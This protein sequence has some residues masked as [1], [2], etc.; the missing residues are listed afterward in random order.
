MDNG[1]RHRQ[2]AARQAE[3]SIWPECSCCR[4]IEHYQLLIEAEALETLSLKELCHAERLVFEALAC[5][6]KHCPENHIRAYCARQ[7]A[8][9]WWE[10][11]RNNDFAAILDRAVKRMGT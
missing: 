1:R 5:A 9:R 4:I 10:D 6:A 7:V 2:L 11:Y 3:C 8:D